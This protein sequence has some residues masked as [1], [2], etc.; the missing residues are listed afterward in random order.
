MAPITGSGTTNSVP[1]FTS[2]SN[3]GDSIIKEISGKVGIGSATPAVTLD[4]NGI[5]QLTGFKMPTGAINN[6]VLTSDVTGVGTWKQLNAVAGGGTTNALPRFTGAN[7]IGDSAIHESAGNIGIGTTTPG[8]KLDV[9]GNVNING[10]VQALQSMLALSGLIG[11]STNPATP[12]GVFDGAAGGKII[13]GQVGGVEKFSVDGTGKVVADGGIQFSDGS[14]QTTAR[15]DSNLATEMPGPTGVD[16]H[17]DEEGNDNFQLQ[18]DDYYFVIVAEDR[19]GGM[20]LPSVEVYC[21]VN[22]GSLH[23][24]A[25]Y[26]NPAIGA[27]RYRIYIG[28]TS[29]A[30]DRFLFSDTNPFAPD[31][32]SPY[33]DQAVRFL[34]D[35]RNAVN[36]ITT[37]PATGLQVVVPQVATAIINKLSVEG[38]SWISGGNLG[39]GTTNPMESLEVAGAARID[40]LNFRKAEGVGW[41]DARITVSYAPMSSHPQLQITG[42][43][44]D[45]RI[46][47]IGLFGETY[48]N[49][50]LY[51]SGDTTI[52]GTVHLEGNVG[53][54]T[55]DPKVPLQIKRG[56]VI[57]LH[58]LPGARVYFFNDETTD[59][60][61]GTDNGE[62]SQNFN[63]HNYSLGLTAM[64]VNHATNFVGIGTQQPQ[65][66]LHV[67]GYLRISE[68]V[69]VGKDLSAQGLYERSSKRW[70]K[71]IEPLTDALNT[72]QHLQ[73]VSFDWK[74]DGRH[75]IGFIA[76][77]VGN[78]VPEVV[79]YEENGEDAKGVDYGRL[80][81][82]LV[83][84][85]KEQQNQI[86]ELKAMVKSLLADKEMATV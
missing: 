78:T 36:E 13:S 80:T 34:Y 1:K 74:E 56:G 32:G 49:S 27:A 28:N 24:I 73:G 51:V 42:A 39:I 20:S 6:Y 59:W 25:L 40:R 55:S 10:S 50:K 71:N 31:E 29:G 67:E 75:D 47:R 45:E 58:G 7:A 68:G 79:T 43:G 46:P 15:P 30:Q 5:I 53:I 26:W 54:G 22:S 63:L 83:E 66:K 57:Y 3:L 18:E 12:A 52:S 2:A 21:T 17:T 61:L 62:H 4:V 33:G 8:A 38:P 44:D 23:K 11:R 60:A 77:D 76:E 69:W 84:A 72:V 70:K 14:I 64:S 16:A 82:I 81:A 41:R 37:D 85:V 65:E 9:N 19:N 86:D 35:A 48:I